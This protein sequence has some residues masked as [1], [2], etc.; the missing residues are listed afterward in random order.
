MTVGWDW[1]DWEE[2]GRCGLGLDGL[3]R[4][5]WEW[6]IIGWVG[7][8]GIGVGWDWMCWERRSEFGLGLNV[9]RREW[10]V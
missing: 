7:E 2:K 6:A 1:M 9:L 10:W 5:G 4:E 3:G 8:G